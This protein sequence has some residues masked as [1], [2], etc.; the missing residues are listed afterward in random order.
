MPIGTIGVGTGMLIAGLE[1]RR[2]GLE[3]SQSVRD[4]HA[5][6][7]VMVVPYVNR[8]GGGLALAGRF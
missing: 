7:A 2:Q 6:T 5:A 8:D 4:A 1:L 3:R